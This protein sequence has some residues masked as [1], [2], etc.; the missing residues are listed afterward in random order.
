M[1][2][3][4]RQYLFDYLMEEFRKFPEVRVRM[5]PY[6]EPGTEDDGV[7]VR[8]EAREFFFETIWVVGQRMDLVTGLVGK[9]REGLE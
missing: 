7:Q 8:T 6:R 9:I 4:A 3:V 2:E 5:V 1:T